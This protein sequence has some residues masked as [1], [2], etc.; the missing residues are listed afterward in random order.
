MYVDIKELAFERK[1]ILRNTYI[2]FQKGEFISILGANGSGKSSFYKALLGLIKY[3]G[4]SDIPQQEIAVVSDYVSLP[5]ETPVQDIIDFVC[6]HGR[7]TEELKTLSTMLGINDML[8]TKVRS[9]SSG[10]KRKLELFVALLSGRKVIIYD[11]I[12]AN[13]D[14]PSKD[15]IIPFIKEY[16]SFHD[17]MLVF[18][19]SHDLR[20]IMKFVGKKL[21]IN[22]KSKQFEDVTDYSAEDIAMKL[23][24][25]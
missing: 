3:K 16:H 4:S 21:L 9:L 17:D 23:A 20:E 13:I 19:S 15:V 22:P 7:A 18:Y 11:E 10:Q 14:E 24:S 5:N 2:S 12:T 6:K 8:K 25:L 1:E